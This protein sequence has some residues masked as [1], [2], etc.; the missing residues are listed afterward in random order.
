MDSKKSNS[1]STL[2]TSRL[3]FGLAATLIFFIVSGTVSYLNTRSL[4]NNALLVT[5]T[6]E[7]LTALSDLLSLVK[8]A[9]TGQRGYLITGE[10]S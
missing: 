5:H 8:D 7:V 1:L 10:P 4:S 2:S 6:H 3:W 9:E